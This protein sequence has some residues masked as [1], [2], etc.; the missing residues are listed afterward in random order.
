MSSQQQEQTREGEALEPAQDKIEDDLAPIFAACIENRAKE[1]GVAVL[2]LAAL[3]LELSQFIE[4]G[5]T[6]TSTLM[7][8]V[9]RAPWQVVVVGSSHHEVAG[10]SSLNAALRAAPLRLAH[11]ARGAFD[12][13][14][15]CLAVS[16]L[17]A[18]SC[19]PDAPAGAAASKSHYLAFGAAGALLQ[20]L[21]A[22]AGAVIAPGSLRMCSNLAITRQRPAGAPAATKDPTL[23]IASQVE[24][25]ILLRCLLRALPALS[26][27]MA[28]VATPL[29]GAVRSNLVR[30]ELQDLLADVE[31]ALEEEAQAS[32]GA[33]AGRMHQ[34]WAVRSNVDPFL[35]MAR[36]TFNR[37]T[38][39][40][41]SLAEKQRAEPALAGLKAKYTHAKG[42]HFVL[43][44]PKPATGPAAVAAT[45]PQLPRGFL[46]LEQRG[47]GQVLATTH[48]LNAL[49]AR[50]RDA[51]ADA[52]MLTQQASGRKPYC[53]QTQALKVL[54]GLVSK[55]LAQMPLLLQAR[56]GAQSLHGHGVMIIDSVALL[57]M[58]VSFFQA[59]TGSP[60]EYV[61]PRI[62]P[63]GPLAVTAGRH[64][65]LEALLHNR[66]GPAAAAAAAAGLDAPPARPGR[67]QG[68]GAAGG[69]SGAAAV[70][71][72]PVAY[73]A[74]DTYASEAATLHL[75][76]GPNMAGKSTYLKQARRVAMLVI[77]AQMGCY[78]PASFM[79][80]TPFDRIFTRI[81]TADNIESNASSF[82]VEMAETAA[83]VSQATDRS[84]VLIDEL[85]RATS[86]ADG[87]GLAWAVCEYLLTLGCPT[88]L[89]THF[90]QL[91]ELASLYP[92]CRLWR[93]QA[94]RGA[95]RASGSKSPQRPA[96]VFR[97]GRWGVDVAGDSLH[98]RWS[99]VSADDAG[100][101][102]GSDSDAATHYG[103]ALARALGMPEPLLRR[104]AAVSGMLESENR[105]RAAAAEASGAG[106]GE[107]V[108]GSGGAGKGGGARALRQV[109]SLVHR[110]GCVAR[111]AAAAG[112]G[113][114]GPGRGAGGGGGGG[115]DAEGAAAF[116][117]AAVAAALPLL[118]ELKAE[119]ER[120][121]FGE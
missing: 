25:V 43:P 19:K 38:E 64:P 59:V 26:E 93:M 84:L 91:E 16:E 54:D 120:L 68:P 52:I 66:H 95:R 102:G 60:H 92:S 58:L 15:G 85:G 39:A 101:G 81:G 83:I 99:M 62:T 40:I 6:Y 97:A 78:V 48:E 24:A 30:P 3:R 61:R 82:M 56:P 117:E 105:A 22:G 31:A 77:M 18:A 35:D 34:V 42:W 115:G 112:R 51:A 86:T 41:R 119:A 87:V 96:A 45:Q 100:G 118:R 46:V 14:R 12:D 121:C 44:Q 71:V 27:S 107:G 21:S 2:D 49:N 29:L 50:L 80:L 13:T 69:G 33:F 65:L 89:A 5:H 90:R 110:L 17:A 10:S 7:H 76:T 73:A 108:R 37:L 111:H 32:K 72:A 98:Y 9:P 116:G 28:W 4:P 114:E 63:S 104:A 67:R 11:A 109:Y 53:S 8:L 47:R 103:I 94:R 1:V 113:G 23:K 88:L 79:S 106:E 75:I 20:H 74:N 36:T 70:F 57:D 55:A